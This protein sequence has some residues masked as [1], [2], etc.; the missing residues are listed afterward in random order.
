M[1]PGLSVVAFVVE[2]KGGYWILGKA[3]EAFPS[4]LSLSKVAVKLAV[5]LLHF[6]FAI[7]GFEIINK[8]A[9]SHHKSSIFLMKDNV[10]FFSDIL[11]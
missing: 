1:K 8:T 2:S 9:S 6:V 5:R 3:S 10:V 4:G 7:L 11:S